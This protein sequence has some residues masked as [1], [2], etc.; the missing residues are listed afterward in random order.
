MDCAVVLILERDLCLTLTAN[1]SSSEEESESSHLR[2]GG[3]EE[4]EEEDAIGWVLLLWSKKCVLDLRLC[5][6]AAVWLK[7]GFLV[8]FFEKVR[9]MDKNAA[10][11]KYCAARSLVDVIRLHLLTSQFRKG[12]KQRM[13][14]F[15]QAH[16]ALFVEL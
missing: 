16:H 8:S 14:V 10:R 9:K 2:I 1:A 12:S 7:N 4:E 15:A 11:F 5:S 3:L 6:F 13:T